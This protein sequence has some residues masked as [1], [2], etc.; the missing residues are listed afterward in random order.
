MS[1]RIWLTAG[2]IFAAIVAVLL[3]VNPYGAA[4]AQNDAMV[5]ADD[6]APLVADTQAGK[7]SFT[8][9]IADDAGERERGLM[10][11]QQMDDRHGMLF[12]FEATQPVGF[13]MKNTSLPLD[14]V[15]IRQDGKVSA[16]LHGEP[17]SEAIVAPDEPVRFVLELNAGTAKKAGIETG[18]RIHH[19]VIDKVTGATQ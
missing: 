1:R 11:R 12:V 5:M 17:M 14:L 6:P 19:P 18:V 8:V 10:F 4:R 7:R 13:W 2:I 9:E 3:Y 15:F 16:V